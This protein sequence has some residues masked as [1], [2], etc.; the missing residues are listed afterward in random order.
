MQDKRYFTAEDRKVGNI[1][2]PEDFPLDEQGRL[3]GD[4]RAELSDI[5]ASIRRAMRHLPV[6]YE[7]DMQRAMDALNLALAK[8]VVEQMNKTWE[9][10]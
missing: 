8:I 1:P 7:S 6:Q 3:I 5:R 10:K 4:V 9:R 2:Q